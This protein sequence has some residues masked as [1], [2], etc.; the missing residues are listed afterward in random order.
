MYGSDAKKAVACKYMYNKY[1][2]VKQHKSK[3]YVLELGI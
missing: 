1:Y 3:W 2:H